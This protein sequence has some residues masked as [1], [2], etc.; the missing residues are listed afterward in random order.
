MSQNYYELLGITKNASKQE[1][2]K[3]FRAKAKEH[4]PDKGGDEA[5]FK[6]INQA[7]ET[8]SDEQKRAYYDQFGSS[9]GMGGGGF[10]GGMGGFDFGGQAG[11]MGGFEDVFSSF[12]GFGGR[13]SQSKT[14]KQKG[15]D[16]EVEVLLTFDESINGVVKMFPAKIYET[17]E[18]CDGEGGFDKQECRTCHGSGQ[19]TQ[20]F[21]TP[22]GVI[23]QKTT[24][25]TCQGN[26]KLFKK[27]CNKCKGEGRIEK[28]TKIEVK[29]PAGIAHGTTLR[30]R[31][32]GDAGKNGGQNGDLFVHV[33]VRESNKFKRNRLNLMSELEISV[34]DAILGGIFEV[35][36]F[37]GKVDLKIPE[38]TQ[39]NQFLKIS[40]KGV[41]TNSQVG[42]HLVQI[43]YKLPKKITKK[44]KEILEEAKKES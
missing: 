8:L 1:I 36:T 22:F 35:E 12:F 5:K 25:S 37:W 13:Q 30:V 40:G 10:S 43:K 28:K 21:Q 23:Q 27:I 15:A 11:E 26:G 9:A 31:G 6:E 20:K 38:N 3:A 29:I 41:K 17:C 14:R 33:Q 16:L 18:K 32:K 34:F 39:D 19:A 2:K 7:Y 4:H 44:L 24:C 42:D